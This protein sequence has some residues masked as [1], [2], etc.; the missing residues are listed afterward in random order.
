[1]NGMGRSVVCLTAEGIGLF[2]QRKGMSLDDSTQYKK[3]NNYGQIITESKL[4]CTPIIM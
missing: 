1:M 4:F 2:S 3:F